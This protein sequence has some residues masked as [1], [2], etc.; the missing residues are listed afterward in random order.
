MNSREVS[1][2]IRDHQGV[3]LGPIH[4]SNHR[5]RCASCGMEWNRDESPLDDGTM[6]LWMVLSLMD[7]ISLADDPFDI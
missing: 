1:L 5:F 4:L 3:C 6:T 2:A 7:T